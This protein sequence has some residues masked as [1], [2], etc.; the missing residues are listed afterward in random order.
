[1]RPSGYSFIT[2][3]SLLP[4]AA[5]LLRQPS[6]Q[7]A[8]SDFSGRPAFSASLTCSQMRCRY[9]VD[10]VYGQGNKRRVRR[11]HLA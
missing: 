4:P 9:V 5:T 1:V 7:I 8:T 2:L 11:L 3:T 10:N 6:V